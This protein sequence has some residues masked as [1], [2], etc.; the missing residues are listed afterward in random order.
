MKNDS[1][2]AIAVG[3]LVLIAGAVLLS[4]PRCKRGCRTVGEHLFEDGIKTLL[5]S[6]VL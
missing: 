5:E 1:S 4:N 3:F 2:N 6:L